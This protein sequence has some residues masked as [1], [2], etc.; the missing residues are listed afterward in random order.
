MPRINTDQG[1]P[2]IMFVCLTQIINH[3]ELTLDEL[4]LATAP[5]N[6][7]AIF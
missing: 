2:V 6:K 5:I 3:H 7:L 4:P 1:P